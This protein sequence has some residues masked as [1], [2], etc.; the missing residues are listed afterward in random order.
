MLTG[1]IR[2]TL[3]EKWMEQAATEM[4]LLEPGLKHDITTMVDSAFL[5]SM[6]WSERASG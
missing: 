6:P 5:L 3:R 4:L 2:I 1:R